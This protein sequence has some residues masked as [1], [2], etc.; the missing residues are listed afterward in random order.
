MINVTIMCG[1]VALETNTIMLTSTDRDYKFPAR[2]V[3]AMYVHDNWGGFCFGWK[4]R[5]AVG[6]IL[7]LLMELCGATHV[8][9]FSVI[10][11]LWH[12]EPIV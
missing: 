3:W 11:Y 9:W 4:N 5:P 12:Y 7:T 6:R 1:Y 10:S 2:I 8:G